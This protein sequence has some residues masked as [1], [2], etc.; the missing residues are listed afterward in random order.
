MVDGI[1]D[2][3]FV[4]ML[5]FLIFIAICGLIQGSRAAK[6]MDKHYELLYEWLEYIKQQDPDE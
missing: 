4:V 1:A 6:R 2:W 5:G 3:L